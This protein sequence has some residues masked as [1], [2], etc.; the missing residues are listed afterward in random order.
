[1]FSMYGCKF[2]ACIEQP[3]SKVHYSW[4]SII[5]V[6]SRVVSDYGLFSQDDDPSKGKWLEP[7]RTLDFY[8]LKSGVSNYYSANVRLSA[9][10]HR[11]QYPVLSEGFFR[12]SIIYLSC[13]H[14]IWVSF[15]SFLSSTIKSSS[16]FQV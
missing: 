2:T 11:M 15:A 3:S 5:S 9:F 1:M 4:W 14:G 8:P 16:V 7:A 12:I 13:L 6:L 10:F